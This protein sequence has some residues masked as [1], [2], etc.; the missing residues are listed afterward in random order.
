MKKKRIKTRETSNNLRWFSCENPDKAH[1]VT[2]MAPILYLQEN[3][4][5]PRIYWH[6]RR[7]FLLI[8]FRNFLLFADKNKNFQLKYRN[9]YSNEMLRSY[10]NLK[11]ITTVVHLIWIN[12]FHKHFKEL[13]THYNAL[14]KWYQFNL[15]KRGLLDY[16][17]AATYCS[18][19]KIT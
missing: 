11:S 7:N 3:F 6:K 8:F 4:L 14:L 5:P 16:K 15:L 17:H 10:V 9:M 2:F 1:S 12:K 13:N 19:R 18:C